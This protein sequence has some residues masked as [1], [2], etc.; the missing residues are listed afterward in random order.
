MTTKSG[1]I[2]HSLA[3][4]PDVP[5]GAVL[6]HHKDFKSAILVCPDRQAVCFSKLNWRAPETLPLTPKWCYIN[7]PGMLEGAVVTERK[8]FESVLE[9]ERRLEP[10]Q[11]NFRQ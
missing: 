2:R 8:D 1:S 4:L 5:S 7:L 10:R 3:C 6:A 11:S 9:I